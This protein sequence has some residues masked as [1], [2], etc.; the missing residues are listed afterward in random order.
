MAREEIN[1]QALDDVVGGKFSFYTNSK[2]QPRVNITGIGVYAC[3]S[4][5]FISY[6]NTKA[7]NPDASEQ[8]LFSM[9]QAAGVIYGNKLA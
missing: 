1:E 9:L 7:A 8:E 2:G 4:S 5:G 3:T 6:I